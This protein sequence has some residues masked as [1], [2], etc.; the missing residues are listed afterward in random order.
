MINFIKKDKLLELLNSKG[1]FHTIYNHQPLFTVSDSEK[2][3]GNIDGVHS[4]NLFLKNKQNKF[5][6]FS[7]L[8]NQI[9]NIKKISK[10]LS[11]GNVSF[12]NEEKL[13][14]IL[15]LKAGSVSPFG[16]LNDKNKFVQFFLDKKIYESKTVNFH[17]MINTST[18]N[19]KTSDFIKVLLVNQIIINVFDFDTYSIIKTI[20]NE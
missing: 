19:L 13:F 17:P 20:T 4:K 14:E 1:F 18:I 8:E 10:S 12:A 7:C 16:L 6:L 2:F 15:G 3:R 9:F 11:L 5:F